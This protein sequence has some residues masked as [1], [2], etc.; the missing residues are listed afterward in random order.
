MISVTFDDT[1]KRIRALLVKDFKLDPGMLT[2]DARLDELGVDS[3]GMIELIFNVE[4]EFRLKLPEIVGPLPTFGEVVRVIDAAV[5][6]QRAT[7]VPSPLAHG[8]PTAS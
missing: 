3:I 2:A 5:A 7:A 6:D 4:D 1:E 8:V